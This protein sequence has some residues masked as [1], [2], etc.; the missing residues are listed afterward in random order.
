MPVPLGELAAVLGLD[1]LAV[2]PLPITGITCDSRN[3]DPGFVFVA[4]RGERYDG[5]AFIPEACLRGAR[6]VVAETRQHVVPVPCLLVPDSRLALAKLA[7]HFHGHPSR[8]LEV[9]GVTGTNGKT[10]TACLLHHILQT[11]GRASGLIGTVAVKYATRTLP[12]GLTTP[13]ADELQAHLAAMRSEGLQSV[14][15]EVSSQGIKTQR[16]AGM[17]FSFG[18][19]TNITLDHLD[20]HAT[21]REYIGTKRRFLDMLAPD[22]TVFV[23]RDDLGARSLLPELKARVVTFGFHPASQLQVVSEHPAAGPARF[24]LRISRAIDTHRS[25]LLPLNLPLTLPLLGAHNMANAAAAVGV[26]LGL[27]VEPHFIQEALATFPGVERRLEVFRLADLT[28]VDDTALN[29]ASLDA[30][31]RVVAALPHQRLVVVYA[32]RGGRSPAVN[33][34]NALALGEWGHRLAFAALVTTSS[35]AHVGEVDRVRPEEE[36]A[37]FAGLAT[38]GLTCLHFPDL[39]DAVAAALA[40]TR[41][42]DLLL[43]L[44]AQ[45]MDAGRAV[46][47][48]LWA[49]RQAAL[50]PTRHA[51]AAWAGY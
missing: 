28:V 3:V 7:A 33:R 13:G 20:T 32:L 16:I 24:T 21:F 4:L 37:F 35:V 38:A 30:V 50:L 19:L 34:I 45:G 25:T 5:H 8:A 17:H 51:A 49:E 47:Q 42:G 18:I 11:A 10:T 41:P 12:A 1:P 22:R 43:L 15:M 39:R 26:A 14:V 27:G 36:E 31:F 46:L 6:A 44:G 48:D 23:N 2:A 9:I 29:P 40:R